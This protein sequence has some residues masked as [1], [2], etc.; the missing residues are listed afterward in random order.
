MEPE[1]VK[2]CYRRVQVTIAEGKWAKALQLLSAYLKTVP[3]GERKPFE[4]LMPEVLKAIGDNGRVQGL[5]ERRAAL[6]S[7]ITEGMK[8]R[9]DINGLVEEYIKLGGPIEDDNI[10]LQAMLQQAPAQYDGNQNLEQSID[11]MV[12]VLRD[13]KKQVDLSEETYRSLVDEK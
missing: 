1:N 11:L 8:E 5:K 2:A 6:L 10:K 13:M 3:Q 9:R 7:E 4:D 12:C